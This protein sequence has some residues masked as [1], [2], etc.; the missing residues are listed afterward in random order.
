M[1]EDAPQRRYELREMF[2]M[3]RR[4]A[5]AGASWRMLPTRFPPWEMVYQ[6]TQHGLNAGCFEAMV[7]DLR[8]VP[9]VAQ[10]RQSQPSAVIPDRRPLQST[11][12]SGP[13]GL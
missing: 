1:S 9:R 4:M 8:S 12:E 3:L 13:R 7:N 2:N 5:R 10:E 11:C 6:Q